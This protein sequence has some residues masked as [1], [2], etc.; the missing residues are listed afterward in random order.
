MIAIP[1]HRPSPTMPSSWT[2]T[3]GSFG[4][5]A[6]PMTWRIRLREDP[7]FWATQLLPAPR[8]RALY[9]LHA[10]CREIEAIAHSE[11]SAS[12][13]QALLSGWRSEIAL[14]Y[15]GRPR[16]ALARSL[17][18]PVR[19]YGLRCNDFLR[20]IDGWET[21][22]RAGRQAP[23]LPE[24]DFHCSQ[25]AGGIGLLA[26][27][28]L[29]L[30]TPAAERIAAEL[31][32]AVRLTEL[33]RDLSADAA[34]NRLYLPHEL[35]AAHGLLSD[36]PR[37]VLTHPALANVCGELATL[38]EE[39]YAAAAKAIAASRSPGARVAALILATYR[40]ILQEVRARGWKHLEKPI[41]LSAGRKARL[42]L[43][44][45]LATV[46]SFGI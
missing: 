44:Y 35:L 13:K 9:A 21:D 12:L 11:A 1:D 33:L 6:R 8:T 19:L 4:Q 3:G 37:S 22:S 15:E 29:G 43:G 46:K 32:R 25:T 24:L 42:A 5:G 31:G 18:G 45:A 38:A 10:F 39:H 17:M 26:M 23:S 27:G 41:R 20:I 2:G 30:E 40:A 36:S 16:H 34:R 28:I 14:L 7:L